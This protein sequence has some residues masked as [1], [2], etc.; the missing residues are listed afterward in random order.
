MPYINHVTGRRRDN[1]LLSH[2]KKCSILPMMLI[3]FFLVLYVKKKKER[4]FDK[5][6]L[7]AKCLY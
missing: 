7:I 3:E 6:L 5:N 2:P 4:K 1:L